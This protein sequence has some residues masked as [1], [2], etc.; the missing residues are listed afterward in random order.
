MKDQNK[1][2]KGQAAIPAAAPL[3]L[4]QIFEHPRTGQVLTVLAS[5]SLLLLFICLPLVGRAGAAVPW[6]RKNF[7]TFLAVLMISL[8]LAG[9]ATASKLLRRTRDNSPFPRVSAALAGICLFFL[10]TL[11]AGLLSI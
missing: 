5:L 1:K 10:V 9:L 11:L 6:A 3:D 8:L 7:L 2:K 4:A